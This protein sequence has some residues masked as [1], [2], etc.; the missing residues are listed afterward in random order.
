MRVLN[1]STTRQNQLYS[2]LLPQHSLIPSQ[3]KD[4][5]PEA[6]V[7]AQVNKVRL[8]PYFKGYFSFPMLDNNGHTSTLEVILMAQVKGENLWQV[9]GDSGVSLDD[10]LNISAQVSSQLARLHA[11]KLVHMDVKGANI[12]IDNAGGKVSCSCL[13]QCDTVHHMQ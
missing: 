2:F 4:L 7:L 3:T 12:M 6:L 11:C 10:A 5:L 9:Q 8:G 13:L 1:V